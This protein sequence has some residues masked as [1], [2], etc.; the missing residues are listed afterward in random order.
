MLVGFHEATSG[1]A[2]IFGYSIRDEI[3][4]IQSIMGLCPQFDILVS[5]TR[6]VLLPKLSREILK[7]FL[8]ISIYLCVVVE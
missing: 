5:K 6:E 1:D 8:G 3:G 2:N 4:N 7:H